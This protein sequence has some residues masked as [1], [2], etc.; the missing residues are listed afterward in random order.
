M[1]VN[2]LVDRQIASISLDQPPEPSDDYGGPTE[3][4]PSI[5]EDSTPLPE[6]IIPEQRVSASFVHSK[7]GKKKKK[8]M[9]KMYS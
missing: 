7:K 2:V 6:T 1:R 4:S 9:M 3:H 5:V 8:K